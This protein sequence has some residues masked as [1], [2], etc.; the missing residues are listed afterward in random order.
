MNIK[1]LK[2]KIRTTKASLT[3][4]YFALSAETDDVIYQALHSIYMVTWNE[5]KQ[6]KLLK[7]GWY[8]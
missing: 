8:E 7:R 6:L 3:K 1:Y 5:Y 2:H 4:L